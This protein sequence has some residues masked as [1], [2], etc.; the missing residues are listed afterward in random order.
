MIVEEVHWAP[1]FSTV[2]AIES[3]LMWMQVDDDGDSGCPCLPEPPVFNLSP[4]PLPVLDADF[5]Q[6]SGSSAP[7]DALTCP[8][9]ALEDNL[10]SFYST[11]HDGYFPT[12]PVSPIVFVIGVVTVTA[13]VAVSIMALA[14]FLARRTPKRN[15]IKTTAALRDNGCFHC[16]GQNAINS[17]PS[18]TVQE[19]SVKSDLSC[20]SV[21]PILKGYFPNLVRI[22]ERSAQMN[23]PDG[24]SAIYEEISSGYYVGSAENS[25]TESA[26]FAPVVSNESTLKNLE[27]FSSMSGNCVGQF[28]DFMSHQNKLRCA[29]S[30]SPGV[31]LKTGSTSGE[32][33]YPSSKYK[34]TLR[35]DR[36]LNSTGF[37]DEVRIPSKAAVVMD[38]PW[39]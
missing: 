13:L 12:V 21:R 9:E 10:N 5:K 18:P 36:H 37:L 26:C 15:G 38:G 2:N 32:A 23:C 27:T 29:R 1:E 33:G 4:P 31:T 19:S 28:A 24:A 39:L 3:S 30:T 14:F 22:S 16:Y 25:T 20:Y 17:A 35:N 8:V 34:L 6:A 7:F 11:M